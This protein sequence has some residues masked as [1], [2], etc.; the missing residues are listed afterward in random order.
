MKVNYST[1]RDE[2][3]GW[4][5]VQAMGEDLAK[6]PDDGM[7]DVSLTINGVEMDVLAA[8]DKLEK[9]IDNQCSEDSD[10]NAYKRG[11]NEGVRQVKCR[12]YDELDA[13]PEIEE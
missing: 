10:N 6:I 1:V 12:I 11:Y 7:Y 5:L 8:I 4:F 13:M 3:I 9:H 2:L